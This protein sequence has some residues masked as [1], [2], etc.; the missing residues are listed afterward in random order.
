MSKGHVKDIKKGVKRTSKGR[1][2]GC[3]KGVQRTSK[4]RKKGRQKGRLKDVKRTPQGRLKGVK[5]A[6][7][8]VDFIKLIFPKIFRIDS[9]QLISEKS[10]CKG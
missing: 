10:P 1:Q 5:R 2:Q 7:K 3:P 6:S 9:H 8:G 4:G